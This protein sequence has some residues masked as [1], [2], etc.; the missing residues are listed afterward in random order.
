MTTQPEAAIVNAILKALNDLPQT[1]V[2]K[3]HGNRYSVAWP[4]I[5]GTHHGQAI[6]LEVK[7]PTGKVTAR[8]THEL[9][10]W[11]RGGALCGVVRSV[12][13]ALAV[14]RGEHALTHSEVVGD[15]PDRMHTGTTDEF[16]RAVRRRIR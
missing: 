3:T 11:R 4:D 14:L 16:V 12:D 9:A 1:Y 8:Q 2:R 13:E 10:K 6:A 5:V 15:R 7:T